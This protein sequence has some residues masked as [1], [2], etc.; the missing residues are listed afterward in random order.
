MMDI[1]DHKAKPT[2]MAMQEFKMQLLEFAADPNVTGDELFRIDIANAA[3]MI[4]VL[5]EHARLVCAA[6]DFDKCEAVLAAAINPLPLEE[7]LK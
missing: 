4:R 1:H 2:Y 7:T 5:A 3:C 6:V